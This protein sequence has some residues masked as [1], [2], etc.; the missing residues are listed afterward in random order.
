MIIANNLIIFDFDKENK[1]ILSKEFQ[2][3]NNFT[4]TWSLLIKIIK[5]LKIKIECLSYVAK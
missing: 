4:L 1:I 5:K 3:N 2:E